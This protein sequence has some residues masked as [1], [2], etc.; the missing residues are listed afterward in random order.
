[1]R[2]NPK[3]SLILPCMI[4]G[5]VFFGWKPSIIILALA[6]SSSLVILTSQHSFRRLSEQFFPIVLL[7]SRPANVSTLPYMTN[8]LITDC[9][10]R[11]PELFPI[12][13]QS[14]IFFLRSTLSSFIFH[15]MMLA[16]EWQGI[17]HLATHNNNSVFSALCLCK[18]IWH[19]FSFL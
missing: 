16:S 12:L 6:K 10:E 11:L 3:T 7:L 9:A 8:L 14:I 5:T 4:V 2:N 18:V 1:M 17:S 13:W 19:A 15:I